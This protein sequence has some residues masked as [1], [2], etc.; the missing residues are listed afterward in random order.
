MFSRIKFYV[1]ISTLVFAAV[2]LQISTGS[3]SPEHYGREA[4]MDIYLF[5]VDRRLEIPAA[6]VTVACTRI[7]DRPHELIQ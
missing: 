4:I 3:R 6:W 5:T 2:D 7:D 1:W